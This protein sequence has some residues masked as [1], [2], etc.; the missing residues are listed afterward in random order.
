M[1]MI[2]Y[3]DMKIEPNPKGRKPLPEE[4]QMKKAA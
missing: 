1:A 4:Q 2:I 3:P